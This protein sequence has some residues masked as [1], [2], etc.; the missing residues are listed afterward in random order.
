MKS[1]LMIPF[2]RCFANALIG[3]ILLTL[4]TPASLLAELGSN[5]NDAEYLAKYGTNRRQKTC[6]SRT[7][8][9]TGPISVAQAMKYA[10]CDKEGDSRYGGNYFLDIFSL[11][12]SPP[13]PVN[14]KETSIYGRTIDKSKP[15]YD[16]K[17]RAVQYGCVSIIPP[18]KPGKNCLTWGSR[19][20][21]S[22]NSVGSCYQDFAGKWRCN[23]SP[24][25][26]KSVWFQPPP[27]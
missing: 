3:C 1:K 12:V 22:I 19:D 7:E 26:Y 20:S 18:S 23:L 13:R 8:P 2:Q 25:D 16:I 5:L 21:D 11:Q 24:V 15:V 6:P 10:I 9:L 4:L 27:N 14:I 17:G